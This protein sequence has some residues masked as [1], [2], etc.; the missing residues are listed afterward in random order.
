MRENVSLL[1]S[2]KDDDGDGGEG[3]GRDNERCM[4]LSMQML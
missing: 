1:L 3:S 4:G 2:N